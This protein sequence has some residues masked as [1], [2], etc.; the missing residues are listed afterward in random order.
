MVHYIE[1][2]VITNQFSFS[3]V[4]QKVE[5]VVIHIFPFVLIIFDLL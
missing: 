4:A 2:I 3:K 1:K 5:R